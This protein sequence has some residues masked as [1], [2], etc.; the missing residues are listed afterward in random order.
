M[1]RDP[2]GLGFLDP[3][4]FAAKTQILWLLDSLGF[5]WILSSEY[6]LINGLRG[7]GEQK[8]FTPLLPWRGSPETGSDGRGRTEGQD[9]SSGKLTS[10][11]DFPQLIVFEALPLGRLSGS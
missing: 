8:F 4:R 11:S 9:C 5:P 2:V 6:R 3:T 10:L 1:D 7:T